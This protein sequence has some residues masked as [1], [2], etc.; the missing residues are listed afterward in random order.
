MP[1]PYTQ[2]Y[3][4]ALLSPPSPM[5]AQLKPFPR[6]PVLPGYDLPPVPQTGTRVILLRHG[7]S[8]LND[9]GCYQ[10][11][12]DTSYLTPAG[13]AA[14]KVVG[15]YLAYCPIDAVYAS[16]L[17]RVQQT[18]ATLMPQ[19]KVPLL[20]DVMTTPLLKEIHLP[21]WEGRRYADVRS[22]DADRYHC[23]QAQPEQLQMTAA[24]AANNVPFYPVRDVYQRAQQ[25]WETTLPQ[26][27][28]ETMLVVGHGGSN[29]ALINTALGLSPHHHHALQ[30]THS[31]LTV[32]DFASPADRAAKL[33][34]LNTTVSDRLPKLKAGKQGLR[35]LLLPCHPNAPKQPEIAAFLKG[36]TI[37]AAI[38]EESAAASRSRETLQTA[39]AA[40]PHNPA[41]VM[42]SV[43]QMQLSQQWPAAIRRS[44]TTYDHEH[45][46]T[47]LV[48]APTESLQA[49]FQSLLG[50]PETAATP[51]LRAHSLS[52]IHYAKTQPQPILQGLNLV[53][54]QP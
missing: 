8:T 44:L 28:G 17:K 41:T 46:T 40:L 27:L 7:R 42:L 11:S 30:Q 14:S 12:T 20:R 32:L 15:R 34:V 26:H 5:I 39:D 33:H 6:Q 2:P 35:L 43:Q 51:Q 22:H 3:F 47:L 23:W 4:S 21:A 54:L 45:L 1:C 25:F 36:E 53:P 16:P 31:G 19:L 18:V 29:Q 24:G 37:D 52:V 50:L 49:G 48:V 38:V 13:T 10:G 9:A